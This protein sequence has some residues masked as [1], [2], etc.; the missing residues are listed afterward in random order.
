MLK[1]RTL[2]ALTI[3]HIFDLINYIIHSGLVFRNNEKK[4][5]GLITYNYHSIEKGFSMPIIKYGFGQEKIKALIKLVFAYISKNNNTGS[6]QFVAGCSVLVKYYILH[7]EA[8][9][10]ISS[11]FK[12]GD[13]EELRKYSDPEIGGSITIDEK[14]YFIEPC[15]DYSH[16]SRSRHSV[17]YFSPEQI[18]MG[19]IEKAIDLARFCPSACNRQASKVYLVEDRNKISDILK[20][21]KGLLAT[22]D[23]VSQLLVVTS[24][25]NYFFTSGERNQLFIDGGIFLQSMLLA[26]HHEKIAACPLHWS[27]SF[28][29]DFKIKKMLKLSNGEKVISLIAIGNVANNFKVPAS[30]RRGID[31]ILTII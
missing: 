18:E 12:E 25:R 14:N 8:K 27:L 28:R 13:Y 2:T 29:E 22:E 10:D 26:L 16:F 5:E 7:K 4:L 17:R 23:F 9:F 1:I 15:P 31:E 6:S 20:I 30:H 11:F 19:K 21:Q 24:N 3:N